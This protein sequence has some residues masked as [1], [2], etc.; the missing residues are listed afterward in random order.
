[1]STTEHALELE[2]G[3]V[4]G[5][6]LLLDS[7]NATL[8]EI[9]PT[10]IPVL[11][12]GESGTG[13][14]V[15]ARLLHKLSGCSGEL[16]KV[17]CSIATPAYFSQSLSQP[18][19]TISDAGTIFL[20]G[21][22]ELDSDCQRALLCI[23]PEAQQQNETDAMFPRLVSSTSRNLEECVDA[24]LFRK[25]LYFR[26]NGVCLR[27][28]SLRQRK[29]DIPALLQ[30]F[31]AKHSVLFERPVPA[32]DQQTIE[33]I[34][35]YDWPGN[36]RQL[37]NLA[38][39]IVALG[40]S[41]FVMSDLGTGRTDRTECIKLQGTGSLKV[42]AK[43][44]SRQREREM[45]LEALERTKWNRKRAARELQISYKALLYKLK[46]IGSLETRIQN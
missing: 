18:A 19:S 44:A 25:E 5:Q 6:S 9:A 15:Y 40:N 23:L 28:P 17:S 16:K 42:A 37:E 32:I 21:I 12:R 38:R 7:V 20:N 24:G 10:N 29:E 46:Q 14:E 39:K 35:S 36:I 22:D 30:H 33:A 43:A 31:L 3:F 27:L 2:V 11:I 45:I 41:H 1:M 4:P 26:L 13:K 34:T 8:S